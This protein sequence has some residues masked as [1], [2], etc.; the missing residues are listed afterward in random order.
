MTN[1]FNA[2]PMVLVSD[3]AERKP[4]L[5]YIKVELVGTAS[6][7]NGLGAK[8]TL[9]T[10]AGA[11]T[12]VQ[13]GRSGYLSQSVIPLYFGLAAGTDVERVRVVWP[14]GRSQIVDRPIELN[15]LLRIEENG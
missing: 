9:E 3:L 2:E 7:R 4:D 5:R 15:T 10:G 6:N 1:E 13:D 12:Q 11:F 14:S 8:V